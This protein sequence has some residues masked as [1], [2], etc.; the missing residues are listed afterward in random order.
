ML[1]TIFLA[2]LAI[3][4]A[5]AA[6]PVGQC[7]GTTSTDPDARIRCLVAASATSSTM[8]V[9]DRKQTHL[10]LGDA[11]FAAGRFEHA[12]KVYRAAAVRQVQPPAPSPE[13]PAL[14]PP[15]PWALGNVN[16]IRRWINEY[17][18]RD[19]VTP[20]PRLQKWDRY[21]DVY[22]R[23]FAKFRGTAANILEIG[24]QSGG[25]LL[26]WREYFGPSIFCGALF[27]V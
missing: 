14:P 2:V 6:R 7:R 20:Q 19:A 8:S 27:L 25:S 5:I 3:V 9:S 24:V 13:S 11:L 15:Q 23:H 10:A 17:A 21:L 18:R 12:A 22:H 26:M 1:A 16:P 4:G